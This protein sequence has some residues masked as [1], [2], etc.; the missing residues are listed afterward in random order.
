MGCKHGPLECAVPPTVYSKTV[1]QHL[2]ADVADFV[3]F[4]PFSFLSYTTWDQLSL[5]ILFLF[6]NVK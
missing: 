6:G 4:S 2:T 5:W 1:D 3:I